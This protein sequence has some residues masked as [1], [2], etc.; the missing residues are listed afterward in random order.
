M[1]KNK[2]IILVFS[3]ILIDQLTKIIAVNLLNNSIV[4]FEDFFQFQ[5]A[6]NL[7]SA[8][9]ILSGRIIIIISLVALYYLSKLTYEFIDQKYTLIGL[10][11]MIAG[12]IGNL[13]DRIFRGGVID[14]LDFQIF[15]YDYPIFNLADTF[16]VIGLL[17]IIIDY[18]VDEIKNKKKKE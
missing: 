12:T 7:G 17:L 10:N 4:I 5:L 11:L 16:L 15:N 9:S 14:F 2:Q 8:W 1:S 13:I 3:L 18:I 6:I